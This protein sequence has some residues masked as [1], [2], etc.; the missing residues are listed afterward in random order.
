MGTCDMAERVALVTGGNRGLGLAVARGLAQGG[1]RVVLASRDEAAGSAAGARLTSEGWRVS[2]V[3]LD[4][5]DPQSVRAAAKTVGQS[6]GRLDVLVNNAGILPE[7]TNA[8]PVEILDSAMFEQTYATNLLG[9]V[10]MLEAFLPLLRKS[11]SARVVNVTTTMGSLAD[12]T[13]PESAYYGTVMPAYQ[14]SKAALNNVTIALAKLL[15]DSHIKVTSVCPGFVQT[16]LTPMNRQEAP[17]TAEQAAEVVVQ[18]AAL[19]NQAE[20]GTFVDANGRVPW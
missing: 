16:D 15:K 18:A 14:S 12:Q 19:P 8:E 9:P 1:D 3:Q 13:N 11:P 7:A 17:L 6:F 20:S 10:R 5:T 4:V 2:S